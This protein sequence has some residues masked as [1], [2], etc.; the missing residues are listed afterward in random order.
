MK[1]DLGEMEQK[2]LQSRQRGDIVEAVNLY[3]AIVD[4]EPGYEHG[5]IF[6]DLAGCYEDLGEMQLA[7]EA[8]Q[9]AVVHGRGDPTIIG[10]LASFL[11]LHGD[12]KEAIQCYLDLLKIEHTANDTDAVQSTEK[13]LENLAER[14][15]WGQE[16]LRQKIRE[17]LDTSI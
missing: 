14:V 17:A 10:G 15:G 9:Q 13:A 12:P 3:K 16:F 7:L 4:E 8:Y 1:T 11:Y 2:A 5:M 6:Y